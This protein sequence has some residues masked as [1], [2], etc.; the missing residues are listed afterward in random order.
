MK[1]KIAFTLGLI[2]LI[3]SI[4]MLKPAPITAAEEPIEF[5]DALPSIEY[6]ATAGDLGFHAEVGGESFKYAA[7]YAPDG[8]MLFNLRID[9]GLGDQGL[10]GFTFESAEPPLEELPLDEF[11]ARYPE[12]EYTFVG[13]TLEGKKLE[14][15]AEFAHTIPDPPVIISPAEGATVPL[16]AVIIAWEPITT[17]K[18]IEIDVYMLQIFPVDPPEGQDPIEMNIDLLFE[19]PAFVTQVRIPPEFLVS[20]ETYQYEL[21]AVEAEGGHRTITVG[22]LVTE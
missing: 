3:A 18:G 9:G 11:L 20:G 7:I 14:S 19:V 17:P 21:I 16:D 6:N 22:T 1:P 15:V 4:W 13:E 8:T 10:S 2:T 12:G 5:A